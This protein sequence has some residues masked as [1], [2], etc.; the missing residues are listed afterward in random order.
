MNT[1]FPLKLLVITYSV[2]FIVPLFFILHL[3]NNIFL[4]ILKIFLSFWM[5]LV[6]YQADR[7][8]PKITLGPFLCFIGLF[9][10]LRYYFYQFPLNYIFVGFFLIW[11]WG[12]F[13]Q[14]DKI[15][16]EVEKNLSNNHKI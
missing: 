1:A 3:P 4:V 11:F 14:I 7:R 15:H 8:Y 9:F 6:F 5:L 16:E 2:L 10:V 13:K 12:K